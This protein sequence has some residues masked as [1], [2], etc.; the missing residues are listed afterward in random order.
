MPDEALVRVL[1]DAWDLAIASV[2]YRPVGFGSHHWEVRDSNGAR[3]FVTVDDLDGK[4]QS[5][6]DT[7]A[8]AFGRLRA[9]LATALRLSDLG[10]T[11]VVAPIPTLAGEP[12]VW[13]HRQFGVALYP[14]VEG[15]S[16]SWG[17]FSTPA[18]RQGV[19]DLLVALHSAGDAASRNAIEDDFVIPQ[20]AA[21]ERP[22]PGDPSTGPY[23]TW[24][25]RLLA[26]NRRAIHLVLE[27]YDDLAGDVARLAQ[28]PVLTHGEPHPGNTMLTS[29]G[30]VLVD[31][32]TVMLAP[33]ERDLWSMDPGD[34]SVLAAYAHA[35]GRSA[36][37]AALD[38]YRIRWDLADMA[39]CFSQFQRP[40]SGN[41]DDEKTWELLRSLVERLSA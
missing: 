40:H 15:E 12:L 35:T 23:A 3:W 14:F 37:P 30:W 9:A 8:E 41:L 19:L 32:D 36:L 17:V 13:A 16:Y 34:G 5:P 1:R 31:W 25:S 33:P 2:E 21:L 18:H 7:R 11:F 28:R 22:N 24:A 29:S 39:A 4:I 27:R 38:L 20:R 26:K 10:A 6:E